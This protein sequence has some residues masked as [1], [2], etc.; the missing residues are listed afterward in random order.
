MIQAAAFRA[1]DR[2]ADFC[3]EFSRQQWARLGQST[4]M[5]L[6]RDD[7]DALPGLNVLSADEVREVFLPLARLI[8]LHMQARTQ[9]Q[10]AAGALLRCE[11]GPVPF[12][13]GIAGGVAVGKSTS[14]RVLQGVL[15]RLPGHPAVDL[16]STDGFLYPHAELERRGLVMRK[17]FPETYDLPALV[18]F[19]SAV[20]SGQREVAAPVYSHL[21]SN[22]VPDAHQLVN[23]PDILIVEGLNVLQRPAP[24][25]AVSAPDFLDFTIY[26][27][28]D[29][30]HIRQWYLDRCL[31]MRGGVPRDFET[32]DRVWREI[33]YPNLVDNIAPTRERARVI[34]EKAPDHH[35]RGVRLRR[36]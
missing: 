9:V 11:L 16:M 30:S 36:S 4:P 34:L 21:A 10:R 32:A 2:H 7:L 18:T 23:R 13:V 29:P 35:V 22:L 33:N 27:D 17:G 25:P 24:S 19:L 31:E 26:L 3:H 6:H 1:G 15:S 20:R 12:I 5:T 14:A 28:A 8:S